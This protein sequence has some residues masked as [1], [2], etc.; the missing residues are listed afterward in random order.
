MSTPGRSKRKRKPASTRPSTRA[1]TADIAAALVSDPVEDD[2]P[3]YQALIDAAAAHDDSWF[4]R[5]FPAFSRFRRLREERAPI[6]VDIGY[7]HAADLS[8]EDAECIFDLTK[9]NM[10]TL[11]AQ[12][13]SRPVP[14]LSPASLTLTPLLRARSPSYDACET[15]G[16]S[17]DDGSQSAALRTIRRDSPCHAR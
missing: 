14:R 2:L 13:E 7:A 11:S 15:P 8:E 16:W 5:C 9:T 3:R 10:Q 1:Y 12:P 17:W 6:D 4:Q